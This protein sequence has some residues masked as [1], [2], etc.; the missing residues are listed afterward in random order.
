MS[1]DDLHD[2]MDF[3]SRS[4]EVL[5]AMSSSTRLEILQFLTKGERRLDEIAKA[6]KIDSSRIR[7]H[8]AILARARL[9]VEWVR[10]GTPV[11]M[12]HPGHFK[13]SEGGDTFEF[14]FI[15]VDLRIGNVV[16][17]DTA[18]SRGP[19]SVF[20]EKVELNLPWRELYRLDITGVLKTVEE[21][22]DSLGFVYQYGEESI[23]E[24]Y[25]QRLIFQTYRPASR[26]GVAKI[27]EQARKALW[28]SY[29]RVPSHDFSPQ[30]W[31]SAWAISQIADAFDESSM[32][33]GRILLA[34]V[35]RDGEAGFRVAVVPSTAMLEVD[36]IPGFLNEPGRVFDILAEWTVESDDVG[37]SADREGFDDEEDEGRGGVTAGV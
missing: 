12:L 16:P 18:P 23:R 27:F 7:E 4:F 13:Q 19:R 9:I 15:C 5:H 17:K 30:L 25:M 37:R 11:C 10:D 36:A 20:E 31:R 33:L 3:A 8:L 24:A 32:R 22:M 34:K 26:I 6:L 2:S 35:T 29:N 28:L 21:F 14:D 1:D